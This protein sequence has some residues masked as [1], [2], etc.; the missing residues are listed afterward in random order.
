MGSWSRLF[1]RLFGG[2]APV[3]IPHAWCADESIARLTLNAAE[4]LRRRMSAAGLSPAEAV[5]VLQLGA[6]DELG[7]EVRRG[8]GTAYYLY[9]TRARSGSGAGS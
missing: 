4:E 2:A 7:V 6:G 3:R 9:T 1:N 5:V 8:M